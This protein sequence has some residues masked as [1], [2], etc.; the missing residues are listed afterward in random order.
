[1]KSRIKISFLST[2]LAILAMPVV[3]Q[4]TTSTPVTGQTIQDRKENQQDRIANGVKSGELTAG[5]TKNL[6]KKETKLNQEERDMRSL[7]N[8]KLTT[9]EGRWPA[10]FGRRAA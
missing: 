2:A 1:M 4:T 8:G 9:A 7:D 10:P 6:E 5:E 3:A